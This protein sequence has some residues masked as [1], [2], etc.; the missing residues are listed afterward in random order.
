MILRFA[1][2]D[3]LHEDWPNTADHRVWTQT[4]LISSEPRLGPLQVDQSVKQALF[5]C[6]AEGGWAGAS[7]LEKWEG[8]L[9]VR[10]W[11]LHFNDELVC[12]ISFGPKVKGLLK[13]CSEEVFESIM[14]DRKL[15]WCWVSLWQSIKHWMTLELERFLLKFHH[16][17]QFETLLFVKHDFMSWTLEVQPVPSEMTGPEPHAL[18]DS[19]LKLLRCFQESPQCGLETVRSDSMLTWGWY[20]NDAVQLFSGLTGGP[21]TSMWTTQETVLSTGYIIVIFSFFIIHKDFFFYLKSEVKD[22]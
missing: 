2:N 11:N 9:H 5:S 13:T 14:N 21:Q 3:E 17:F 19:R 8:Y 16:L 12:R 7:G 1:H 18:L 6:G 20:Y 15:K 4:R 22:V 10:I